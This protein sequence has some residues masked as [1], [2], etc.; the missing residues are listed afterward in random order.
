MN[1]TTTPQELPTSTEKFSKPTMAKDGTWRYTFQNEEGYGVAEPFATYDE[2]CL[3]MGRYFFEFG[4][5]R[6]TATYEFT[7]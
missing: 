6:V 1:K 2:A 5:R 4:G 7:E 3:H